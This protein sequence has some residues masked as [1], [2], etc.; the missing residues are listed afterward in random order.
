MHRDTGERGIVQVKTGHTRIDASAYEANEKAFLFATCGRYGD[1]IPPRVTIIERA[2]LCGFMRDTPH[3]VPS[4][5][6]VWTDL[7]GLPR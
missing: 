2:K 3:L 6:R 5:V 4:A 7:L 1:K